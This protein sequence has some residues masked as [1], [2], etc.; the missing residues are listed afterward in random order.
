MR[1]QE[2]EMPQAL[3]TAQLDGRPIGQLDRGVSH[4]A[5]IGANIGGADDVLEDEAKQGGNDSVPDHRK[6]EPEHAFRL[7]DIPGV[8]EQSIRLR[9]YAML[10]R[11]LNEESVKRLQI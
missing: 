1:L 6:Y 4:E 10:P 5:V 2:I 8:V 9:R 11:G 3:L 7:E